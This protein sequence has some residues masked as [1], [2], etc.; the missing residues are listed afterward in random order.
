MTRHKLMEDARN[1][2]EATSYILI[3]VKY[4]LVHY[5]VITA[6]FLLLSF[7]SWAIF[8]LY[9][10]Q[11][12]GT[13]RLKIQDAQPIT[14]QAKPI[15]SLL[16]PFDI[17]YAQDK[18]EN[19]IYIGKNVYGFYDPDYKVWKLKDEGVV[20]VWNIKTNAVFKVEIPTLSDESKMKSYVK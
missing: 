18:P 13:D 8:G 17:A 16:L 15:G 1:K 12:Q 14:Q 3:G 7:G 9:Y 20:L 19:P 4:F 6:P 5:P 2:S 11:N 10:Y